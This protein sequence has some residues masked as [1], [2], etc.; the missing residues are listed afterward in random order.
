MVTV[1]ICSECSGLAYYSLLNFVSDKANC[2]YLVNSFGLSETDCPF[3]SLAKPYLLRQQRQSEW[4]GTILGGQGE[5]VNV[6]YYTVTPGSINLV[7]SAT[8]S[9][10]TWLKYSNPPLPE[11]LGFIR[12]NQKVVLA[13]VSHEQDAWLELED[14]EFESFKVLATKEGI[15]FSV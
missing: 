6:M 5:G 12:P 15:E 1:N 10:Y 14:D 9:L 8:T 7:H 3:L 11:D 2:F 4:P 13:S